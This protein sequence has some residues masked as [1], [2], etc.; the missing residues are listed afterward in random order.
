M[1]KKH[2][3]V[4]VSSPHQHYYACILYYAVDKKNKKYIETEVQAA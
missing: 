1:T 4:I 3:I 2:T